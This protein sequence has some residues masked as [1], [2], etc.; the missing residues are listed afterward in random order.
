MEEYVLF[1]PFISC[2]CRKSMITTIMCFL[3]RNREHVHPYCSMIE[4]KSRS[5][6][7]S[8]RHSLHVMDIQY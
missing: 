2:T 1:L 6:I 3:H 7:V 4:S 5:M 8:P